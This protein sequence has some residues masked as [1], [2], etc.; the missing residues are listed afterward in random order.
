MIGK[1]LRR[2]RILEKVGL[3]LVILVVV[4]S[5]AEAQ[6]RPFAFTVTTMAAADGHGWTAFYDAGYAE[7]TSE[8]FGSDGLEQRLGIQGR[9]GAGF[10]VVGRVGFGVGPGDDGRSTGEAEILKDVLAPASGLRLAVGV[11]ARREWQGGTIQ[12]DFSVPSALVYFRWKRFGMEK[13]S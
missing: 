11:G 2:Y 13:S 8:P 5:T 7:R 6:I 12:L 9:L 1:I 3:L 4:S 10:S